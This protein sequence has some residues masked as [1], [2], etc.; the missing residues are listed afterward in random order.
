MT[1]NQSIDL[2]IDSPCCG[3]LEW[4]EDECA[5]DGAISYN[6]ETRTKTQ[7]RTC[8]L[9]YEH[10]NLVSFDFSFSKKSLKAVLEISANWSS[11]VLCCSARA[12]GFF[13]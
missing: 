11:L 8:S 5:S 4:L 9:T 12:A 13:D 2:L 1:S 7:T 10:G 3:G 6:H